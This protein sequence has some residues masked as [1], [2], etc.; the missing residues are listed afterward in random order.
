M[1]FR[2]R[3]SVNQKLTL[4]LG[5]RWILPH[6]VA[7]RSP[8]RDAG[9]QTLDVLIGGVGGNPKNMGIVAPKDLFTPR[10]GA[11]YR[12]NDETVMRT[13][14]GATL[15][16]RGMSSQEAFRG[17]F[18]YPLVLNASFPPPAGTSTFGWYGTINQGIPRLEGRI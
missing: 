2:D 14:Y 15:D 4:D 3:W 11:V 13:G 16:A 5:V 7:R 9:P 12:L 17:D 6:L 10:V 1:F 8:D 18:S